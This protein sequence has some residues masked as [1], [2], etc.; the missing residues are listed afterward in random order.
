[1]I[2]RVRL[3]RLKLIE[4]NQKID[5]NESQSFVQNEDNNKNYFKKQFD[6]SVTKIDQMVLGY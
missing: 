4:F 3:E 2:D 1:M 6:E 5:P